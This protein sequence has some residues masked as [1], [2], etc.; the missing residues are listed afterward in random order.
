[1]KMFALISRVQGT[2]LI[3]SGLVIT[4]ARPV[5]LIA[6]ASSVPSLKPIGVMTLQAPASTSKWRAVHEGHCLP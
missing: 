2:G 5:L 6:N 1:M 4:A 3:F